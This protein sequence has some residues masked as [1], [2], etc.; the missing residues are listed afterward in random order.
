MSY[1]DSPM[2]S[3]TKQFNSTHDQLTAIKGQQDGSHITNF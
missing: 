3:P 1:N 2:F